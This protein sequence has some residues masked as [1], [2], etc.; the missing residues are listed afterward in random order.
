MCENEWVGTDPGLDDRRVGTTHDVMLPAIV[1]TMGWCT[2]SHSH[3]DRREHDI[4]GGAHAS[5]VKTGI[6][7]HPFVLTHVLHPDHDSGDTDGG[8][9]TQVLGI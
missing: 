4:M 6:C 7:T 5:V 9:G 1:M 3:H 8:I 2:P